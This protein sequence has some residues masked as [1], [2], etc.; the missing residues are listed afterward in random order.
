VDRLDSLRGAAPSHWV[1]EG[2]PI[3]LPDGRGVQGVIEAIDRWRRFAPA[4]ALLF[5]E[6]IPDGIIES[7]LRPIPHLAARYSQELAPQDLAGRVFVKADHALPLAGSIKARGGL[8]AVLCIAERAALEAGLLRVNGDYS[9][10]T[11]PAARKLFSSRQIIVGSTGN[12]GFAVGLAG[13][14]LGFETLVHMSH[15]AK[16]WKKERLK[17]LGVSVVEHRSD[18]S[19]AV[20]AARQGAEALRHAHFIDDERSADLFFGYSAAAGRLA[21]Q[22]IERSI[23]IDADRPLC[24]YLPC[25]VGGAP[26]GVLFGLRALMGPHVWGF[27]AEPSASPCM[28]MRLMGSPET[29]SVYDLGLDNQTIADGLAVAKA[30]DFAFQLIGEQ[31]MGGYTVT[32]AQMLAWVAAAWHEERLRLE[33]SA[34]AGFSV[35]LQDAWRLP[36]YA[37]LRARMSNAT[38]VIWT[39]GGE[40]MPDEEFARLLARAAAAPLPG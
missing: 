29:A 7:T 22:L 35:A 16:A 23:T 28:L 4:L 24:I 37:G 21:E 38:H 27:F 6:Q 34:A 10:L 33:P 13:R 18:Y 20:A 2:E 14:A 36:A 31:V 17:S 32:D 11:T 26:A 12:L 15:D 39:T 3:A 8:Y 5:K 1:R 25:G 9:V 40:L 19:S 30:S